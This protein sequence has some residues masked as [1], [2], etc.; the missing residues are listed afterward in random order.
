MDFEIPKVEVSTLTEAFCTICGFK[1]TNLRKEGWICRCIA[2]RVETALKQSKFMA[3]WSWRDI[4]LEIKRIYCL[5]MQ[6]TN[7]GFEP[8]DQ[9]LE[10]T[11]T[12]V[13][14]RDREGLLLIVIHDET[15]DNFME[16]LNQ[17]QTPKVSIIIGKF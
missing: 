1:S 7:A 14:L 6:E 9:I 3:N 15:V 5:N 8:N 17:P 10:R 13:L 12:H 2:T 11:D 16:K 4:A